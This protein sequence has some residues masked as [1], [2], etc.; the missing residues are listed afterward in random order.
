MRR[1]FNVARIFGW[2]V[3]SEMTFNLKQYAWSEAHH[4]KQS[5]LL[6]VALHHK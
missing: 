6:P 5:F 2:T 4:I 1:Y 3:R